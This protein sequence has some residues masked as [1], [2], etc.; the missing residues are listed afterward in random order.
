MNNLKIPKQVKNLT[1]QKFNNLL[2]VSFC[3]VKNG[4][5]RWNCICDCNNF[6]IVSGAHLK[7]GRIKACGCLSHKPENLTGRVFGMLTVI[8]YNGIINKNKNS[9]KCQCS[10]ENKTIKIVQANHLKS[11]ETK[12]CG[13]L[14]RRT[15]ENNPLWK[16]DIFKD[17]ERKRVNIEYTEWRKYILKRDYY[18][19]QISGKIGEQ[20][21]VHHI[22]NWNDFPEKRLEYSNG[23]TL[24][25]S[26]HKLFHKLYGKVNNTSKQFLEFKSRWDSLEWP[27]FQF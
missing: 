17:R 14:T 3:D 18:K 13:C 25:I 22:F 20:L 21:E 6:K 23:I 26:I 9:W 5:S 11:G 1:G 7:D 15:K 2:V 19:C 4:H 10:C 12:S 16:G 27:D 8:E 24:H